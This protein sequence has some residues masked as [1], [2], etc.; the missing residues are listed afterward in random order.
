[1]PVIPIIFNQ[2]AVL[3][4]DEL[5]KV[6]F[7]YYG[8]PNFTKTKLKNYELYVPVEEEEEVTE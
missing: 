5:S 3:I 1:M 2:N 4:S 6:K 7:T 8:V